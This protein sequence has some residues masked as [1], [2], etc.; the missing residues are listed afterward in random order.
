MVIWLVLRDRKR[1]QRS[2][3]CGFHRQPNRVFNLPV[4]K[5][6]GATG[7]DAGWVA[8]VTCVTPC[9]YPESDLVLVSPEPFPGTPES[10]GVCMN[11]LVT[12]DAS[13]SVE[14][15]PTFHWIH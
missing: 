6:N 3:F 8:E 7:G 4:C 1:L 14:G 13:G 2:F 15:D 9:A 11:E 5:N 12:F 10:V